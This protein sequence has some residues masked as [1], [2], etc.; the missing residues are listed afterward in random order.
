VTS[1]ARGSELAVV[2]EEVRLGVMGAEEAKDKDEELLWEAD[3]VVFLSVFGDRGEE[4]WRHRELRG[5]VQRSV[6]WTM[7]VDEDIC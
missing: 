3:N 2:D 1:L 7:L 5:R 4:W 6:T